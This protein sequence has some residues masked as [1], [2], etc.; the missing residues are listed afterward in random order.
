MVL[1][2]GEGESANNKVLYK[3]ISNEHEDN[4]FHEYAAI[5]FEN[6]LSS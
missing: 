4:L 1:F 6:L 5:S 3:I 2:L